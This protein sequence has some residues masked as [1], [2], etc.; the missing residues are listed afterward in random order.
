MACPLPDCQAPFCRTGGRLWQARS[1]ASANVDAFLAD[2]RA[3]MQETGRR[4][5]GKCFAA[6]Y[7][8]A[9]AEDGECLLS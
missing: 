9:M 8:K 6:V 1:A 7:D 5:A 2:V 4:D 3:Y